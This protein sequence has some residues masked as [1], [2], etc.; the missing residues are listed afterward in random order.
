MNRELMQQ[1]LLDAIGSVVPLR[2]GAYV[3][4]PLATGRRYYELVA[5]GREHIASTIREENE[6]KMKSFVTSL[7]NRLAYPVIDPGL[8]KIQDWTAAEIGDFYL[9]VIEHFAKEIWFMDEWQYS[10]GATKEF[11]FAIAN[12]VSCLD[13]QGFIISG[14]RGLEMISDVATHLTQL[15]IDSSRFVDRI[16][17]IR[18]AISSGG[19]LR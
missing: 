4:G 15:G 11:Q 7:R 10:R 19:T 14:E 16:S 5:S 17:N 12:Q 1:H 13:A 2:G 18:L 3:A 9:K 8:I 6:Q